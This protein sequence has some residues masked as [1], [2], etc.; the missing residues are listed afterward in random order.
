VRR[1]RKSSRFPS[2]TGREGK[3]GRVLAALVESDE[4]REEFRPRRR[5]WRGHP[6]GLLGR[7]GIA[8]DRSTLRKGGQKG[9]L[10]RIARTGSIR[11]VPR[12]YFALLELNWRGISSR[13]TRRSGNPRAIEAYS[14]ELSQR[15]RGR[16]MA[17][18]ISFRR[19]PAQSFR[20]GATGGGSNPGLLCREADRKPSGFALKLA[21]R[22]T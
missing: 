9:D 7:T 12:K 8:G 16:R 4:F 11:R 17:E 21:R 14:L 1:I 20:P 19:V 13:D 10:E 15:R 22:K 5:R 3:L 2:R 6:C 18:L